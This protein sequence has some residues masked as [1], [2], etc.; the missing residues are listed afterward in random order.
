MR[1]CVLSHI[2]LCDPVDC[3][4]P[5]SSVH[6]I[7]Q[8]R[9][10]QWVAISYCKVSEYSVLSVHL[11]R[12]ST[13]WGYWDGS[14]DWLQMGS[15]KVF[16][17]RG[18]ALW[19]NYGNDGSSL[20]LLTITGLCTCRSWSRVKLCETA[21]NASS[22]WNASAP[23]GGVVTWSTTLLS[24]VPHPRY[25]LLLKSSCLLVDSLVLQFLVQFI[26]IK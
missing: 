16:R 11:S 25:L 19:L 23:P 24:P 4:P 20:Q 10:L 21:L 6:R 14:V 12:Q 2:Q 7:S 18:T 3:S 22:C 9:R 8:A 5:G 1:V 15:W 13:D 17:D 26:G